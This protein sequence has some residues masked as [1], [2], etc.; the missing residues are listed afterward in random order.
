MNV[1][2]IG[3]TS[4]AQIFSYGYEKTR[5]FFRARKS[6][7]TKQDGSSSWLVLAEWLG[8]VHTER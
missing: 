7:Q 8:Y 3:H 4:I 5:L 6:K 2:H 1:L